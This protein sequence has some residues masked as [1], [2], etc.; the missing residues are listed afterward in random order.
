MSELIFV[1]L[2]TNLGVLSA[3]TITDP[4]VDGSTLNPSLTTEYI[5]FLSVA[6]LNSF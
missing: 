4:T 5:G 1:A 3:D 2:L 6:F